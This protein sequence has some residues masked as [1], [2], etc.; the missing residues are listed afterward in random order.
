MV[1]IYVTLDIYFIV[2]VLLSCISHH[3]NSIGAGQHFIC[4]SYHSSFTVGHRLIL[5]QRK[6]HGQAFIFQTET[7]PIS[8]LAGNTLPPDRVLEL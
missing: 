5:F 7:Q 2:V 4:N 6:C 8:M 3:N 1:K